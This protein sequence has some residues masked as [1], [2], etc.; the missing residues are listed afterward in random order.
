MLTLDKLEK[1]VCSKLLSL[2]SS[3]LKENRR[4]L[5]KEYKE[6]II[7]PRKERKRIK[8]ELFKI[9]KEREEILILNERRKIKKT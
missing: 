5:R 4:R 9:K 8:E 6:W 7:D 3:Y 1:V 2:N